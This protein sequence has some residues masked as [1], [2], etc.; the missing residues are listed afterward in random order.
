MGE[1]IGTTDGISTSQ[2]CHVVSVSC[3]R[4]PQT[5]TKYT[6]DWQNPSP[7]PHL[8][9]VVKLAAAIDH[10]HAARQ[11]ALGLHID[12]KVLRGMRLEEKKITEEKRAGGLKGERINIVHESGCC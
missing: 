6:L 9:V 3:S 10:H 7:S 12:V 2:A 11:L 8:R 5:S 4:L 1:E